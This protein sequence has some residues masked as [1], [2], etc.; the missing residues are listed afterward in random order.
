MRPLGEEFHHSLTKQAGNAKL[1]AMLDQIRDQIRSVW[2]MSILAPRRVQGLIH[3]HLSIIDALKRGDA[4]RAERLMVL[5][6]AG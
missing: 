3:E 2:T 5:H 4:R 1:A 6:A